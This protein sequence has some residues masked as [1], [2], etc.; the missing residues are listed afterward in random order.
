MMEYL[1]NKKLNTETN[2]YS[3]KR[4]TVQQDSNLAGKHQIGYFKK[5]SKL[6]QN[7]NTFQ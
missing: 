2:D 6:E 1:G 7:Y 4:Q 3:F 5:A